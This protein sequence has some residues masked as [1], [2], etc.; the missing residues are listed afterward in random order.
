MTEPH[1]LDVL[2]PRAHDASELR[3]L[4]AYATAY[5]STR[6]VAERIA[7]RLRE[8]GIAVDLLP[9]AEIDRVDPY[10]VVVFGSPVYGQRWLPEGERFVRSNLG[11]LA[12]RDT[13]LFSVGT[14]GDRKRVVGP[15]MRREPRDIDELRRAIR[16]RDYRV[17]A[18]VIE[19]DRWPRVSRLLYH[20][21][22]GRLGDNRDWPAVDDWSHD[23][24]EALQAP[25]A[26][27]SARR[28]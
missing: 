20:A 16:P 4:V 2:G 5:G 26:E 1:H 10:D 12:C 15:L 14:F 21:L 24:V 22:G 3:I 13:W 17:F 9:A 27:R 28:H 8:R 23:I 25:R 18:G 6:G 11:A 19:R 7:A